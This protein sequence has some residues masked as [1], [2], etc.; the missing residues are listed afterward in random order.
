M[1]DSERIQTRLTISK[2]PGSA[3]NV[4]RA[5]SFLREHNGLASKLKDESASGSQ[6]GNVLVGNL[7][8]DKH[9]RNCLLSMQN[10]LPPRTGP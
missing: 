10:F 9:T 3:S 5:M 2:A 1:L 7:R 6:T 4:H 8:L